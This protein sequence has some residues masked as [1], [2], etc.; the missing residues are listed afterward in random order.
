MDLS[1][2]PDRAI[3][4]PC[5]RITTNGEADELRHPRSS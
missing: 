1:K 2:S 3:I 5:G 4:L